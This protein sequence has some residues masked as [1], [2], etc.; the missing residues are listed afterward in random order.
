[1]PLLFMLALMA[2]GLAGCAAEGVGMR[3]AGWG[4]PSTERPLWRRD[5]PPASG[6]GIRYASPEGMDRA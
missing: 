6:P 3:G 4:G 2:I 5:P 1:M